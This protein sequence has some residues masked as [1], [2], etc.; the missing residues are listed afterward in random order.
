MARL[1]SQADLGFVPLPDPCASMIAS[2]LTADSQARM[3]D[4]CAGE[5][6]AAMT[7]A[8]HLRLASDH[9]YLNEL[10]DAR[11]EACRAHTPHVLCCDALLALE[12]TKG[13]FQLA[14]VNAPFDT[15]SGMLN[16]GRLEEKFAA[17][18]VE[19]RLVQ[20][21][22]IVIMVAPR[23]V[24][25]R[26]RF[27]RHLAMCYDALRVVAL[28]AA[29]R[30]YREAVTF[31]VVRA[32]W[33]SGTERREHMRRVEQL[34]VEPLTTLEQ[35]AVAIPEYVVPPPQPVKRFVWRDSARATPT[36]AMHEVA[37]SGGAWRSRQYEQLK[38]RLDHASLST[39]FPLDKRKAALRI[40]AG[41]ING[42]AIELAGATQWIKGSTVE[43]TRQWTETRNTAQ[44]RTTETHTITLRVPHVATVEAGSGAVRLYRGDQGLAALMQ[45]DGAADELMAAVKESVVYR[46]R[47]QMLP[48]VANVLGS[49]QPRSGRALPGYAPGLLWMQ[50]LVAAALHTALTTPD[51]SCKN[52]IPNAVVCSAEMGVGKTNI[53]MAVAELLHR[54]DHD[55]TPR[56]A[57]TTIVSG[58]N[59]VIGEKD[60]LDRYL[61]GRAAEAP[62]WYAE[63]SDLLPGWSI[64]ILETPWD[65]AQ[66]FRAARRDT[67]TPRVGM[68]AH[69]KLSLGSG[70]T[71]GAEQMDSRFRRLQATRLACIDEEAE[72]DEVEARHTRQSTTI[73]QRRAGAASRTEVD[74]A[75]EIGTAT[76]PGVSAR[77]RHRDSFL[78]PPRSLVRRL[79]PSVDGFCA[80]VYQTHPLNR[81]GLCCP[82]CARRV[83]GAHGEPATAGELK[84]RGLAKVRCAMCDEPLGQM[85]RVQD[86][87]HDRSLSVF[88]LGRHRPLHPLVPWGRRPESNPRYA[89]GPL[90]RDRYQGMVD[91]YIADEVHDAKSSTSAIG[92]A[93][94]AVVTAARRTV[95]LTGTF[96]GGYASSIYALL[97]RLGSRPV[98]ERWGW[99]NQKR[100]VDEAGVTD[101]V[102][103]EIQR[104]NDAGHFSGEPRVEVDTQER[105][106]I[107]ATL[108]AVVQNIAVQVL[109]SHM[110]FNLVD[111]QEQLVLLDLPPDMLAAY[112]QL[113]D[114]GKKIIGQGGY[115]ALSSYLQAT[116]QY[117]YQPW[118]PKPIISRIKHLEATTRAFPPDA[119]LPHH[120]WLAE[121]AARHVRD[122]RRVLV[123]T[124]HTGTDDIMPDLA[125]KVARLAAER[126]GSVLHVAILRAGTVPPGERR[127]WFAER[128]RDGTNVVVCNP[129]LVKTGLN[130]IG[131]PSIVVLEPI[132]SLFTLAQAK[133]RAFRPTQT[134]D[135]EVTYVAYS[136]TMSEQAVQVIARKTAAAAILSGDDLES[137]VMELDPGMSLLKELATMLTASTSDDRA[138]D[139]RTHL[140]AGS[141]ALRSTL[142]GQTIEFLG[143][144]P[145]T[146]APV[147]SETP[148][149]AAQSA[150]L[151]VEEPEPAPANSGVV[152]AP[153][154]AI[155]WRT[156]TLRRRGRARTTM[157]P[158][159][160][161]EEVIQ[162]AMF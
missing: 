71:T 133:R 59:H 129:R 99:D 33:R 57:F 63:W 11:A 124:E 20:P 91:L 31:G 12:A 126:F 137:G 131:W 135:C 40:A 2:Y 28:P 64:E 97:L 123:Y 90:I 66:F 100:F 7:I 98:L 74:D 162:Y 17:R 67:G 58:P 76:E 24:L 118:N 155:Q 116:L 145:R 150:V 140:A 23:D 43:E 86:N 127:A 146:L 3:V 36:E 136:D 56:R 44:S 46:F 49:L 81:H 13:M 154:E 45:L 19:G 120:E 82:R 79:R 29:L 53:G 83:I 47:M 87:R 115:D 119:V 52:I 18:I 147:V 96:Y 151:Q 9:V 144:D 158:D 161:A 104:I 143:V 80:P 112:R 54:L 111:Y 125:A 8:G 149:I 41:E 157:R 39:I 50:Q 84:R 6:Q 88:T 85:A 92:Q 62:Q 14:Y 139:V 121:Y 93:F 69:S 73:T 48:A 108:A 95:A 38:T 27:V 78:I 72:A 42:R 61:A 55:A 75:G 70:Y 68:I 26:E 1:A 34:L 30:R 156:I 160:G 65:V 130:L 22:G 21:G 132:Y 113:A 51:P 101:V 152:L 77:T 37:R 4:P 5:G 94:G 109:L 60:Q 128:E 89:L 141:R 102:R 110:G 117:P 103:R 10:H 122:G 148:W 15:D 106:G 25:A 16:G 114:G 138:D 134:R 142:G 159:T 105:P 32:T 153:D 107:T 35:R